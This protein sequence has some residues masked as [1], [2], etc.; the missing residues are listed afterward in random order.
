[1]HRVTLIASGQP[2]GGAPLSESTLVILSIGSGQFEA[3]AY[4]SSTSPVRLASG[5]ERVCIQYEA[6]DTTFA[7][8]DVDRSTVSL[9]WAEG[10]PIDRIQAVSSEQLSFLDLDGNGVLELAACF[11]RG[12]LRVL[13]GSLKPGVQT[14]DATLGGMLSSGGRFEAALHLTVDPQLSL[15][16]VGPNPTRAPTLSFRTTIP[17]PAWLGV[18]DARG[19]LLAVPLNERALASGFHDIGLARSSSAAGVY[20][21][22]LR[23]ADGASTGRFVV[24]K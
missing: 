8:S 3:R 13:F 20:F 1:M 22:R 7:L 2:P 14:V 15:A 10:I 24:L 19:R 18:F 11:S 23:T 17:G 4:P 16:A 9:T 21:Y 12:D 6:L 5:P